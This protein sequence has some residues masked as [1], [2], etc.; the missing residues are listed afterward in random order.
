[1]MLQP[2]ID[3]KSLILSLMCHPVPEYSVSCAIPVPGKH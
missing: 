1:V 2:Q 3:F